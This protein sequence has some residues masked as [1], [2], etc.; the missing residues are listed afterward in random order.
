MVMGDVPAET[1]LVVIGGGVGGYSAAFHAADL[2]L[3]VTLVNE[4]PRLGGVCLLRGCIPSKTLLSLCDL[5]FSARDATS[6]GIRFGDPEIDIE[7]IRAWKDRVVDRLTGG[8]DRLAQD[9]SVKLIQG[10][11]RF[12]GPNRLHIHGEEEVDLSFGHAVLASG[13]RAV[14]LPFADFG[15]AIWKAAD[16]LQLEEVPESLLVVGGGY[17]GLEMSTIYAALGSRVTLVEKE[18][19]LMPE[20][21]QDLV[22]P[23][24]RRIRDLVDGVHVGC[25]VA[26]MEEGDDEVRVSFQGEDPPEDGAFKRVLVAIGRTPASDDLGLEDAGVELRDD[27]SVVVDAERRTT[28]DSILAV[29]DVGGGPFLAHKALREGRVAAEVLAGEPAAFDARAIPAV[30]FTDPEVAWCG[31]T[32]KD[33]EAE[34]RR[35]EVVRFPWQASG[36]AVT[37]GEGEGLTKLLLEPETE[38]ILGM[39]IVGPGAES[40][41]AEG[42]LAMEM[43]AVARDLAHTI[44]PHPTLT[45][46]VQEA[47]EEAL[48]RATHA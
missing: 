39:G 11:A 19:R 9:R 26:E 29:G 46:T 7:K 44:H 4:E 1:D 37:M 2:G 17:V 32:E 31:L 48:D 21:D 15:G 3:E 22:E 42:A 45:E 47:A 6:K 8:L 18:D 25:S 41:I 13:S 34:D 5:L 27:G 20:A 23:V 30:I 40:L 38:R 16:A 43:G 24:A 35:V 10:R 36:R 14:P 28:S 12:A 33:A